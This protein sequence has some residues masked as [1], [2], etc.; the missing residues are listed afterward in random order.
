MLKKILGLVLVSML[1]VGLD[2]GLGSY[3]AAQAV[4]SC[5]SG[6]ICFYDNSNGT[7]LLFQVAASITTKSV[8]YLTPSLSNDRTSYIGNSSGSYW[9]V[10]SNSTCSST[11]G[12]IY[13]NSQGAMVAPWNNSITSY[14]RAT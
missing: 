14:Y 7:T 3:E 13:P 10:F 9:Y 11:P 2:E 12:E 6:S 5:P 1:A 4:S 8:C